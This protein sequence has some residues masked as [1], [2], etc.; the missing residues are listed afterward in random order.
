MR[1]IQYSSLEEIAGFFDMSVGKM[2]E[3]VHIS[4]STLSRRKR[5]GELQEMESDRVA[6]LAD[7]MRT[8]TDLFD[9]DVAATRE[10]MLR[11]R[12]ALGGLSPLECAQTH[13]GAEA[14]KELV[15]KLMNGVFV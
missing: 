8:A 15:M 11:P 13:R 4:S 3:T 12:E 5:E 14:V 2:A 7:V 9:G 10:W 1:K 6:R